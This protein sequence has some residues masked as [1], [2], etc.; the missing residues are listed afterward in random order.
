MRVAFNLEIV[1]CDPH[2]AVCCSYIGFD[3]ENLNF[4]VCLSWLLNEGDR[5]EVPFLAQFPLHFP[6]VF[7]K[8]F[9][10]SNLFVF[11]NV[12]KGSCLYRLGDGSVMSRTVQLI[13]VNSF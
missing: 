4:I 2:D 9:D 12:G 6:W 3:E 7:K 11:M 13:I 5:G 1:V 10:R 8:Q